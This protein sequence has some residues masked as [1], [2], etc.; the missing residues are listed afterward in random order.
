[1]AESVFLQALLIPLFQCSADAPLATNF[2]ARL[3]V[4][5]DISN[6]L[7]NASW[8]ISIPPT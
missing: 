6:T 5:D 7:P 1:M 3:I 4:F 8:Q 2:I